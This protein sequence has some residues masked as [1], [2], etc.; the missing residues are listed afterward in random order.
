MVPNS[1]K[2][3]PTPQR[4]KASSGLDGGRGA[5]HRDDQ[6]AGQGGDLDRHPHDAHVVGQQ[7]QGLGAHEDL[8]GDVVG[9]EAQASKASAAMAP[10]EKTAVV[11]PIR[12]DSTTS[13]TFS[14]SACVQPW[15][16]PGWPNR[17]SDRMKPAAETAMLASAAGRSRGIATSSSAPTQGRK[18]SAQ[19]RVNRHQGLSPRWRSRKPISMV[20]NRSPDLEDEDAADHQQHHHQRGGGQLDH[21]RHAGDADRGE[22][23]PVLHRHQPDHLQDG[24]APGDH[25]QHPQQHDGQGERQILPRDGADAGGDR[26]HHEDGERHQRHAGDHARP[27]AEGGLHR[28]VQVERR[29]RV[30]SAS[31]ISTALATKATSAVR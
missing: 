31:G 15:M 11:S 19:A 2:A 1:A 20:S 29:S 5:V 24:V 28:A 9:A 3:I 25:H 8:E 22:D 13:G 16:P 18:T 4:M 23:Q 12:K 6:H 30:R 26:Q 17:N 7:R 10:S 21:Q 14:A 27:D